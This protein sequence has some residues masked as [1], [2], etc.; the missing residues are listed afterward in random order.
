[1]IRK[2]SLTTLT[3]GALLLSGCGGGGG[4]STDPMN[5]KN[6]IVIISNVAPGVCESEELQLALSETGLRDFL[7]RETD[8]TSSCATY[9]KNNDG[10][11]CT[12]DLSGTGDRN[13]VVGFNEIPPGY[14]G[15]TRQT[16]PEKL[17]NTMELISVNFQ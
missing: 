10:E 2:L 6:Y 14:R 3:L 1:M 4:G 5:D 15:L 12:I 17:Y 7:T 11:Q 16:T 13:C 9:G 8:N